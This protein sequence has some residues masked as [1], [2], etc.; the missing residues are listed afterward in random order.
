VSILDNP[1]QVRHEFLLQQ[2]REIE[3]MLVERGA[4]DTGVTT[5]E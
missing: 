3:E 2:W 5:L 4:T 1:D